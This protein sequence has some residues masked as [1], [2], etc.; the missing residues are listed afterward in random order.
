MQPHLALGVVDVLADEQFIQPSQSAASCG[1]SA[2][3]VVNIV[4][5]NGCTLVHSQNIAAVLCQAAHGQQQKPSGVGKCVAT[6][7][8]TAVANLAKTDKRL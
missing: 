1:R 4:K 6:R 5:R 7:S 2:I 8:R 3:A